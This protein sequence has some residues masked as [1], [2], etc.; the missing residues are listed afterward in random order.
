[1]VN[2]PVVAE[3]GVSWAEGITN[4][5]GE[6]VGNMVSEE[7]VAVSYTCK[8]HHEKETGTASKEMKCISDPASCSLGTLALCNKVATGGNV[9]VYE[10]GTY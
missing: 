9:H 4:G 1:M 10:L 5:T 3:N 6:C 8:N 2:V 7:A